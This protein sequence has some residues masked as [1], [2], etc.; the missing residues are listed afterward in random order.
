MWITTQWYCDDCDVHHECHSCDRMIPF[1]KKYLK[2]YNKRLLKNIEDNKVKPK[3]NEY[4][5]E[6]VDE[7]DSKQKWFYDDWR[8]W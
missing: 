5:D 4:V 6:Y 8:Y 2:D 3:E 7:Y 1:L